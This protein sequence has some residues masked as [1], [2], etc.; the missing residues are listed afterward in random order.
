V[1][2]RIS[3]AGT[4]WD[5]EADSIREAFK[6]AWGDK[7]PA[8]LGFATLIQDLD[9]RGQPIRGTKLFLYSPTAL[10]MA[11]LVGPA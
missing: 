6:K 9:D 1:K 8:A 10:Q 3:T 7:P 5:V 2:I 11:G 4:K